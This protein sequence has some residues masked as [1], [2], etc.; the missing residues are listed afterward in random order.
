M[1]GRGSPLEIPPPVALPGFFLNV[2]FTVAGYKFCVGEG[3][4]ALPCLQLA[5]FEYGLRHR[6]FST[7][8]IRLLQSQPLRDAWWNVE[9]A[10]LKAYPSEPNATVQQ[11]VRRHRHDRGTSTA[12]A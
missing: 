6:I 3:R 10:C 11:S 7:I 5:R 12:Q 1:A 2:A 8:R 9:W 4:C